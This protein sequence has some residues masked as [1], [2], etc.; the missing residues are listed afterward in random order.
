MKFTNQPVL[1]LGKI[2]NNYRGASENPKYAEI[3]EKHHFFQL[4]LI[5]NNFS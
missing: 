3:L 2:R 4:Y 5:Q 1:Y